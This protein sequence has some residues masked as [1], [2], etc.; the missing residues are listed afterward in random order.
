MVKNGELI[1][2]WEEEDEQWLVVPAG[3]SDSTPTLGFD[4]ASNGDA[5]SGSAGNCIV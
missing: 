1:K 2:Q 3:S 5:R 4:T